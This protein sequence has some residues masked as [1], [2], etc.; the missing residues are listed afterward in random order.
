[1]RE[2]NRLFGCVGW[3]RCFWAGSLP[4]L[5]VGHWAAVG[6]FNRRA[7]DAQQ[8]WVDIDGDGHHRRSRW[9]ISLHVDTEQ[10][11]WSAIERGRHAAV[12]RHHLVTLDDAQCRTDKDWRATVQ[13]RC[14]PVVQ[15]DRIRVTGKAAK[16]PQK[17]YRTESVMGNW[18][19]SFHPHVIQV[20]ARNTKI[21]N[22][23][24]STSK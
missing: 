12:A 17:T 19:T 14:Y 6:V 9:R 5:V 11:V 3:D 24:R 7:I 13:L 21:E 23:L 18:L 22:Q 4:Y 2:Q 1:M 15:N 16:K 10:R 20:V 8:T